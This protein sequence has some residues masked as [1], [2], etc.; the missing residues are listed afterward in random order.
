[1]L[2]KKLTE[3]SGVSGNEKE[4]RNIILNE[5]KGYVDSVEVDKLGNIIAYK[6]G[7]TNSKKLMILLTWTKLD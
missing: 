1:M 6:K 4:I 3:A 7:I 5:I 2:L